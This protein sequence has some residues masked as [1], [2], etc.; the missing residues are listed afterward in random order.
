MVVLKGGIGHNRFLKTQWEFVDDSLC[1]HRIAFEFGGLF[2]VILVLR[3][4]KFFV[5]KEISISVR[6]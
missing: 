3:E 4:G 1:L 5:L 2:V 6:I